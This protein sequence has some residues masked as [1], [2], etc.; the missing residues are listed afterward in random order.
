MFITKECDYAIRVICSL[1]D[2]EKRTVEFICSQEDVPLA[3][4]YRILKRLENAGFVQSFRGAC[5]GYRLVADL[6]KLTLLDIICTI[7]ERFYVA[8]CVDS[9]FLPATSSLSCKRCAV[10]GEFMRLQQCIT[11]TLTEKT[12]AEILSLSTASP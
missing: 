10:R 12:L 5:G 2:N 6:E 7:Q 1:S 11:S 8:D 4:A 3:F 9:A